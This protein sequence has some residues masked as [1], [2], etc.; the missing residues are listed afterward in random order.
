[1]TE[2]KLK[3]LAFRILDVLR[4]I[5][6]AEHWSKGV[7]I[8]AYHGVT[9]R[10]A[11]GLANL[12]RLHVPKDLFE[13][14]LKLIRSRWAPVAL[15]TLC[16]ALSAG[17]PLPR[18]SVVVTIDDGYRNALT[19]ALPLLRQYSV[20]A[21]LFVVTGSDRSQ[22]WIDR[23]ETAISST[24]A[25]ELRWEDRAL[26]LHSER[27]RLG[28]IRTVVPRLERLGSERE[29]KVQRLVD[30]LGGPA[31]QPD[32]DRD[33]LS[34]DEVRALRDAGVEIG[35]HADL[36]EP[37]TERNAQADAA[38]RA[39]HETLVRELGD[40]RY[41][42]SYPFGAWSDGLAAAA[43]RAGF[44]CA[45][46]GDPGLNRVGGS[47]FS[48]RRQLIGADDDS[49][50]LRAALSGLRALWTRKPWLPR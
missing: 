35:S 32:D 45:V 11:S 25:T 22:M 4:L 40:G 44:Y 26:P 5:S 47:L 29:A 42:L 23:L 7:P 43:R 13:V 6:L 10:P 30:S 36:H 16:E 1:V 17:R 19:V 9:E 33:L 46:T 15:S 3:V 50:R 14:Q 38:L 24:T 48:L 20:P 37:L 2:G 21:T 41:G 39:S 28:A 8:L 12:R 18:R 34:W 31:Q 49:L 27:Q